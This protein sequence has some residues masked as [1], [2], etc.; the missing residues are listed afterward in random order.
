MERG[1]NA[2]G[3]EYRRKL[4]KELG[5]LGMIDAPQ[6][7]VV[8]KIKEDNLMEEK[9]ITMASFILNSGTSEA[10]ALHANIIAF[11]NSLRRSGH[12][13]PTLKNMEDDL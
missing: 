12:M 8:N 10:A 13:D 6:K 9:L 3:E 11:Y 2:P 5:N 1:E 4:E 7:E